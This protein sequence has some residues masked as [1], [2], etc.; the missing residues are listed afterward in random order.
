MI[1]MGKTILLVICVM[2]VVSRGEASLKSHRSFQRLMYQVQSIEAQQENV[3]KTMKEPPPH[4]M[5]AKMARY[6][7]HS[8]DWTALSTI[9]TH[10][11]IVGYPFVNV[12]SVS[13]G[14]VNASSGVPYMY[15]TDLE[16]SI[17]DM[18]KDP[19]ASITMSLA[20]TD[21]CK[22]K[23]YDPESPLCAHVILTGTIEKVVDKKE[24]KFARKALFSRHHE[25]R[26]WPSD[27]GWWFGRLNI[28]KICLLDYFG[29]A[30]D[31]KVSDYFN[32]SPTLQ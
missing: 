3:T 32:S 12:F 16:I 7:V 13:D 8:S 2:L 1:V 14:P 11:P 5:L 31:V 28:A 22:K 23:R 19:R 29:G 26:D 20:Q 17:Q 25:M 24:M 9:S 18:K 4:E 30:K 15:F 6:I 21:Y 10:E 27:H